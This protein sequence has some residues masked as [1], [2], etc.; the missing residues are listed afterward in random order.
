MSDLCHMMEGVFHL[1]DPDF[2][3]GPLV[4]KSLVTNS[5]VTNSRQSKHAA[6]LHSRFRQGDHRP[7]KESGAV[8][9]ETTSSLGASGPIAEKMLR[10]VL[11]GPLFQAAFQ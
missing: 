4:T 1:K 5:L 6:L 7:G 3:I 10:E 8:S 9:V 11:G 2:V